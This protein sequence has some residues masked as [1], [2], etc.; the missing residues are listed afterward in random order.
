MPSDFS[1]D[2]P[3]VVFFNMHGIPFKLSLFA[4][5]CVMYDDVL[6]LSHK[7]LA[8]RRLPLSFPT[9]SHC[10]GRTVLG[11]PPPGGPPPAAV[12]WCNS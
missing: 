7:V 8:S 2:S 9:V 6:Q 10:F 5:V 11:G 1:P 12:V 4:S 3:N